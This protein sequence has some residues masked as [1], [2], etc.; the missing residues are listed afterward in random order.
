[1]SLALHLVLSVWTVALAQPRVWADALP[2]FGHKTILLMRVNFSDDSTPPPLDDAGAAT[3]LQ[4]LN[5]FYV[6]MSYGKIWFTG[7]VTPVL[8]LPKPQ[9]SYGNANRDVM[10]ADARAGR[11][12]G[13]ERHGALA[14][15]G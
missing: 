7:T 15:P 1:M 11:A 14:A 3:L 2:A 9:A 5:A 10:L 8:T 12:V 13:P 4:G 6:E